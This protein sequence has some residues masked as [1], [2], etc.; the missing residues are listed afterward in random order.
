MNN[1]DFKTFWE[2]YLRSSNVSRP[3]FATDPYRIVWNESRRHLAMS[4]LNILAKE[5]PQQ[6]IDALEKEAGLS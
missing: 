6:L 3:T 2:H 4:Y 5:D 1:P